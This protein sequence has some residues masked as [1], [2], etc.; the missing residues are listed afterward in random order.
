MTQE[1]AHKIGLPTIAV[2]A[3]LIANVTFL[4]W[5]QPPGG[6]NPYWQ[7][8]YYYLFAFFQLSNGGAFLLSMTAVMVVTFFP[9]VLPRRPQDASW[10]GSIV[11]ILAVIALIAAFMFA[12]L[13]SCGWDAPPPDCAILSCYMG[14]VPAAQVF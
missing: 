5:A 1:Q 3:V 10:F 8:C 12:G 13:V 6:T 11:L 9:L 4:G 14:G 2:V 7:T